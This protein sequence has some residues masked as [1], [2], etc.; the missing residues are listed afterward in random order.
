M[1]IKELK[2]EYKDIFSTQLRCSVDITFEKKYKPGEA[3]KEFNEKNFIPPSENIA[4]SEV[5]TIVKEKTYRSVWRVDVPVENK[6]TS[7]D[8]TSIQSTA[9]FFREIF[10]K[11]GIPKGT[12]E[13]GNPKNVMYYLDDSQ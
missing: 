13:I 6:L 4:C 5:L 2:N 7:T 10:D 1:S 9:K 8:L 12:G 11:T 3:I